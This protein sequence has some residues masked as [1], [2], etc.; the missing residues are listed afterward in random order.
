M[1]LKN[2]EK[3]RKSWLIDNELFNNRI[4]NIIKRERKLKSDERPYVP[5]RIESIME[6]ENRLSKQFECNNP[7]C[8]ACK[9][10][11]FSLA[12]RGL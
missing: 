5:G 2:L 11:K 10:V 6:F 3:A 1:N 7:N 4:N 8:V 9:S 12:V